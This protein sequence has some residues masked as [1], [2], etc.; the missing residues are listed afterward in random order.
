MVEGASDANRTTILS[1]GESPADSLYVLYWMQASQRTRYNHALE[2][3][4]NEANRR[5]L[6]LVVSF[7][8]TPSYPDAQLRHYKFMLDGLKDV[9]DDLQK[10]GIRFLLLLGDVPAEIVRVGKNA[11]ILYTDRGYLPHQV[12][13]RSIVARALTCRVVQIESDVVVPVSMA[14]NKR[15]YAARTLRPK[16]TAQ[17]S[18]YLSPLERVPARSECYDG[19]IE[20]TFDPRKI[21]L[22][23]VTPRIDSTVAPVQDV[24]GGMRRAAELLERFVTQ[25]LD[26]FALDRNDPIA[27]A[28]SELSPYLHFGQIS[29]IEII[30]EAENA[31][32]KEHESVEV[33]KEELIVRRELAINYVTYEPAFDSYNALPSWARETLDDHR[34]DDREYLYEFEEFNAANTHDPYWNAAMNEMKSTGRMRGYMR[35]YWGKK[36][37]EWSESPE[38]AYEILLTLNNRWFLDGRDP[39]SYANVGWIFGLHDRPWGERPVY[40]KVRYM[41]ANG[42]RRKFDIEEY[43]RRFSQS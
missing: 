19:E 5:D 28:T 31:L 22:A 29:P 1:D 7:C 21:D 25:R 30:L 20:G 3:A 38:R 34:E 35:M 8:L 41:N 40:G 26:R 15:E 14:S 11:A 23:N 36:V 27:T 13:W 32:G 9:A 2:L 4:L 6:P 17:V 43:V 24:H 39:N 18:S 33:L 10:R 42:L 37:L 16:I 12:Q